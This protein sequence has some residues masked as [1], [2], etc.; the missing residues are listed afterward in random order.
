VPFDKEDLSVLIMD[1]LN[2]TISDRIAEESVG[3]YRVYFNV[4]VVG[5]YFFKVFLKNTS[6][7][8]SFTAKAYDLSKIIISDIPKRIVLGQKCCFQGTALARIGM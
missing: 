8:H 1:S 7:I 6:L 3:H 5:S 4:P 2:Q